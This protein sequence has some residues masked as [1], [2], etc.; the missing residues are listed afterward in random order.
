MR[1]PMTAQQRGDAFSWGTYEHVHGP[2][3][4]ISI[5]RVI[6]AKFKEKAQQHIFKPAGAIVDDVLATGVPNYGHSLPKPDN[7]RRKTNRMREKFRPKI[8]PNWTSRQS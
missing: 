2:D 7:L 8:Q 4:G 3:P 1:C 6:A 5:N